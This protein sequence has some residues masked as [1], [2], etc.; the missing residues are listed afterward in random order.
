MRILDKVD[1]FI[2]PCFI[3]FLSHIM[4]YLVSQQFSMVFVL[5]C[6]LYCSNF[7]LEPIFAQAKAFAQAFYTCAGVPWT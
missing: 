6:S 4:F 3:L 2:H 5:F 1:L 7:S